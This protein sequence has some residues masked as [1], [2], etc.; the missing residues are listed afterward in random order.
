LNTIS[1]PTCKF[2]AADMRAAHREWSCN[3]GPAAL[4]AALGITL[5]EVRP[6]LGDFEKKRY[7]NPTDMRNAIYSAGARTYELDSLPNPGVV[8]IQWD[9]P[10]LNEGVPP[11][12]AYRYTHWTAHQW[13]GEESWMFDANGLW[14][15]FHEW[16]TKTIPGITG[17]IPRAT[18]RWFPTHR[19]QVER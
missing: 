9:G 10:W 1:Q 19:W 15:P 13:V 7:M 4:A 14:T 8:R 3:C 5:A 18:G 16:R 11:R 12:V 6:C 2:T 17:R